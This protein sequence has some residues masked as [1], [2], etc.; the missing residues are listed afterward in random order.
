[1]KPGQDKSIP[2]YL[3]H[4]GTNFYAYDLLGCHVQKKNTMLPTMPAITSA[5]WG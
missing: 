5:L 2:L 4:Q 3:F 1:M